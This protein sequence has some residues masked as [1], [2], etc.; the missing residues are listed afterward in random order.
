LL[1]HW[2][3]LLEDGVAASIRQVKPGMS[4]PVRAAL[5][6]DLLVLQSSFAGPLVT[7]DKRTFTSQT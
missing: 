7:L 3:N 5:D 2:P 1:G 6:Q 4:S